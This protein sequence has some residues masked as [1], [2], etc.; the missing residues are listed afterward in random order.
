MDSPAASCKEDLLVEIAYWLPAACACCLVLVGFLFREI[1]LPEIRMARFHRPVSTNLTAYLVSIVNSPDWARS[2][3]LF[4]TWGMDFMRHFPRSLFR[5]SATAACADFS[6]LTL[7]VRS[8]ESG[9]RSFYYLY[10]AAVQHFLEATTLP[11]LIRTTEDCFVNVALLADY[12]ARLSS[13][14]DPYSEVVIQ[15]QVI[16]TG[17]RQWFIHGGSGWVLSRAAAA[18]Y[19][20]DIG[21]L[22]RRYR[23]CAHTGDDALMFHFVRRLPAGPAPRAIDA[24]EFIGGPLSDADIAALRGRRALPPCDADVERAPADL[25]PISAA[26]FWHS[27]RTDNFPMTDGKRV[28]ADRRL[29]FDFAVRP[30][31]VCR[32]GAGDE[33]PP[34][35]RA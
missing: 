4:Q 18:A 24:A 28:Q 1:R 20:A 26:V 34:D 13:A 32:L 17:R 21:A 7:L 19:W 30:S 16:F 2:R 25:R 22:D 11:W 5:F 23:R 8:P 35:A 31:L 9:Y 27:G 15:G 29:A 3:L 14:H 12:I 33:R 6:E 10:R